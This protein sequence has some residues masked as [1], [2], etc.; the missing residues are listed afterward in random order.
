MQLSRPFC[1]LALV[2]PFLR[3]PAYAQPG[4]SGSR[5]HAQI[6]QDLDKALRSTPQYN[7]VKATTVPPASSVDDDLRVRAYRATYGD[8]APEKYATDPQKPI[9]IVLEMGR[10]TLSGVVKNDANQNI[11]GIRA[12][13]VSGVFNPDYQLLALN[14]DNQ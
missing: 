13:Q 14:Q 3:F 7:G 12:K 9:R 8:S 2:F 4:T 5:Y 10:V 1:L 6:Q 11:A